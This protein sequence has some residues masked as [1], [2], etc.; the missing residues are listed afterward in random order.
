MC[1]IA[2]FADLIPERDLDERRRIGEAMSAAL[3]HRGPDGHGL[4][5]DPGGRGALAHRRLAIVDLSPAGAQPMTSASGRYV[6]VYN[7]E[8]YN[9]TE[10][11]AELR[12]RGHR[13]RGGSD[14]EVLL[15]LVD[16]HGL[17]A[18]LPRLTG[19]FALALWDT[20]APTLQLPR[21][22]F[23]EKPLYWGVLGG[24]TVAFASELKALRCH[25]GF[26][27]TIDRAALTQYLRHGWVPGPRTIYEQVAKLPAGHHVTIEL[28]AARIGEPH[29][30]Y[31]LRA[32]AAAGVAQPLPVSLDEAT[33]LLEATLS[34]AVR[35]Q[36]VADVPLGA[37]LSGG[38]DSSTIAALMVAQ[39]TGPVRTF[40]IGFTE[41][42]YDESKHA[43]AV[44]RHLGT[45]HT[46]LIASP[47]ECLPLV[48]QLPHVYDEPF[49]DSSQ[50]PTILLARM[51]RR[52]VTVA[53]S[54]DAGDELFGG[55]S[56]Y[57]LLRSVARLYALPGRRSLAAAATHGLAA[58]LRRTSPMSRARQSI[59]WLRR[60][61][62]F[63]G[64]RDLDG[65]YHRYMSTWHEPAEV[66]PGGHEPPGLLPLRPD[67]LRASPTERAM[68][69]DA[70]LYLCDDVLV[71][72]D[73]AAM[74]T[75]L[76]ARVPLLDPD[77]VELAWRLPL[78]VKVVG[79]LGKVVLR[80]VLARH[81]PRALFERPKA[82]FS[83]PIGTWL[84]GPL[85][86]W[87]EDLLDERRLRDE[88]YLDP[89][90]VRARW[91]AHLAG[92]HDWNYALWIILMW[93][94]WLRA[95]QS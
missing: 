53:L 65:F 29:A 58:L 83:V 38:I 54:G 73:R 95:Q 24:R 10:L 44:A 66:V 8:I 71:K 14:T 86:A 59:E 13:F 31:D 3:V 67:V 82:G 85:R 5:L 74:S 70:L 79:Q 18:T 56:R 57:Q 37:F 39:A 93:Q 36:M 68:L 1:G 92:R 60:R 90:P 91:A 41:H 50:L 47:A 48:E 42:G 46:E 30:Y 26:A 11:R 6:V 20:Q 72:V 4:W 77:V 19:M 64:A 21:S 49:A 23:G 80:N 75:G 94:A 9:H 15:A 81:V 51:T 63:A 16:E 2:G 69:A 78:S 76:E 28:G 87:A 27:A 33:G 61:V 7:G 55:Y 32:V 62:D 35:R 84:R 17:A 52:H 25:P 88:G 43:A 22:R 45:D 89:R 12:A 34:R 40:S